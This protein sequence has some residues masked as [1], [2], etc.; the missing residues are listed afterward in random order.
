MTTG[1]DRGFTLIEVIVALVVLGFVLAGLAQATR[2]GIAAWGVETKMADNAAGLERMD[3]V[4]RRL[5]EQASPPI[6]ADD[7]PFEGQ[8]HKLLFLTLLP[9]QPQTRPIRHAQ[10][11]IGVDDKHRLVLRWQV[12]PNAAAIG[13]P[14]PMH[15]VV[16]AE[17]L[18]RIDLAYRQQAGD[19]GKWAK[20]W[21]DSGLP[22]VVQIHFVL[23]KGAHHWPDMQ[24]ATMLDSNGSF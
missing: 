24:I 10:V 4:L 12:H 17:G 13:P 6:A 1:K 16:L 3:R 23:P 8:E 15:E 18:E 21:S 11:S 2:F 9:D 14:P 20:S 5:V 22:S 19:G 7:K